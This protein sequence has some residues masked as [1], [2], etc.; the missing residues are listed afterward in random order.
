MNELAELEEMEDSEVVLPTTSTPT[1]FAFP[2]AP[3]GPIRV[4]SKTI[5]FSCLDVP[6]HR[7]LLLRQ[8]QLNSKKSKPCGNCKRAWCDLFCSHQTTEHTFVVSRII[9]FEIWCVKVKLRENRLIP[10]K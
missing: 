5:V 6:S 10:S 8:V 1:I 2:D 4:N 9:A 7:V 3:S